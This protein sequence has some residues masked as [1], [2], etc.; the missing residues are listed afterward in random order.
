MTDDLLALLGIYGGTFVVSMIAGLVP[1]VNAEV[2]LIGLVRF[3]VDRLSQLPAIVIAAATGQMVAKIGLY[4]A[5]QGMLDLPR[6]RYKAKIEAVRGKLEQWKTKPYLVYAVSS[7]VGL[8]PFYLTVLAAGAMKIQF[9]AFLG[10]G[11]S[12]RL[13]RFAF[14]VAVAWAA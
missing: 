9:K 12:G 4:Y 1:L 2:F 5:G 14:L 8:P 7:V 10:I 11:L 13:V 3:A 6:G